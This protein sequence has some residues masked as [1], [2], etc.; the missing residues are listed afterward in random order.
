MPTLGGSLSDAKK[1]T[2]IARINVGKV[3]SWKITG[4]FKIYLNVATL[5]FFR[6]NF[7]FMSVHHTVLM[8][9]LGLGTKIT[10]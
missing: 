7:L 4:E 6:L 1:T 5:H 2:L 9:W 10:Q 3:C 8:L